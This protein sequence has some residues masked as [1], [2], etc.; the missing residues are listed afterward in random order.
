MVS[1]VPGGGSFGVPPE[2][3]ARLGDSPRELSRFGSSRVLAGGNLVLKVGPS[4]RATREAFVLGEVGLSSWLGV[5]SLI[6]AGEGWLL[7]RAIDV[8]EPNDPARWHAEALAD[9][10]RLHEAFAG[11]RALN[12]GRLRD[13]TG[14]EL[15]ALAAECRKLAA[16]LNLPE[17]L[18]VLATDLAPLLGELREQDTLLHGDAW[19]GNVLSTKSGARYWIDWEEAG[20]GHAALDLANWLYGSPWV[21]AASD[22]AG[23]LATY[24]TSRETPIDPTGFRRAVDAAVVL[25]FLL[26]DLPGLADCPE[27][28]RNELVER[29]ALTARQFPVWP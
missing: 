6:D 25:L 8:A 12:D 5:P 14:R 29:R 9:L 1:V 17:P 21:P 24:L 3:L 7:L 11:P 16:R 18:R 27:Q 13:I 19:K 4:D 22:P 2:T 28:D 15:P 23:D 10:A 20:V 26:L